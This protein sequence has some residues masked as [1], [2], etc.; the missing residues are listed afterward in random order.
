MEEEF[1][2]VKTEHL[3]H[4]GIIA[5]TIKELGLVEKINQRLELDKNKGGKVSHG[6]RAAA[7]ILNGLG[8]INRTLYLSAHFF[9]DK[10][11]DL[12]LDTEIKADD[13][14]DD[15]LGRHLDK[16][17][18]YGTTKLFSEIAMEICLEQ[19]LFSLIT[20]SNALPPH[21]NHII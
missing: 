18:R 21:S 3:G 10:P 4:L 19:D 9:E 13:I 14:N 6:H 5:S 15:M 16:I 11:L 8:Y 7:M 20:L 17:V 2:S 1:E 12:L